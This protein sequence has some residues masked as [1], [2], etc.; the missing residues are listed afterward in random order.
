MRILSLTPELPYWPG[1]SG[2]AT[3]QFHLLRRLAELGHDVTVVAPATQAQVKHARALEE[4]GVRPLLYERPASRV[5]ETAGV[6]A[7]HPRL[8]AAAV[9][10][11]VFAWQV[12]VLWQRMRPLAARAIREHPPHVVAV[13]HDYGAGWAHDL[14]ADLPAALTFHNLSWRYY[15]SRA[16]AASRTARP[17]FAAEARRFARYDRGHLDRYGL[18]VAV[19]DDD[20]AALRELSGVRV[21]AIPNGVD[22]RALPALPESSA[23]PTLLFTGTLDYPPNAQGIAW[24]VRRVWPSVRA[25]HPDARLTIVGR[26]GGRAVRELGR[27]AGVELAGHVPELGPWFEAATLAIVPVLSGGGTR[28]KA[29]EA[30]SAQR[31]VVSTRLGIAGLGVEPGREALVEDEPEA[32]GRAISSLLQDEEQRRELASAGRRLVEDHFDWRVLGERLA[33]ELERLAA[34]RS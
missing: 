27:E 17:L 10:R 6:L 25:R 15:E 13:E 2:G 12:S 30:M 22:T 33:A 21:A 18:A 4:A 16:A 19:S 24:F 8:A 29:L 34:R 26:G 1:G 23:A 11:P 9:T 5:A 3:R 32:F 14:P 28:L 31:A 20:A 7:R